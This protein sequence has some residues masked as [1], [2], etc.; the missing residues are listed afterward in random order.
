[1]NTVSSTLDIPTGRPRDQVLAKLT[2]KQ[3][4][5]LK[6]IENNA[7]ADFKGDLTQLENALGMLRLGH[8]LGWKTLYLIHSKK[9]VR[10]YEDILGIRIRDVFPETGL[11]SYRSIG[12]NLPFVFPTFG[13][14]S[15]ERP[16][17]PKRKMPY[18]GT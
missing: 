14:S 15:V 17:F 11:S 18:K 5:Q 10:K 9:T 7:I 6:E 3:E 8:H 12:F 2:P 13:K 1:M 4:A 16:K